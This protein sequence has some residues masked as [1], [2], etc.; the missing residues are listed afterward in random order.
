[1]EQ[2][3]KKAFQQNKSGI[4]NQSQI[5]ASDHKFF[6]G[7]LNFRLIGEFKDFACL[8]DLDKKENTP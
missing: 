7:D 4:Q 8:F 6:F 1:M 2:I 5:E 3:H